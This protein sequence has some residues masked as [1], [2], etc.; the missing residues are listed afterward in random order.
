MDVKACELACGETKTR[1][2]CKGGR[3]AKLSP[4][5]IKT[6]RAPGQNR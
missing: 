2:G 4:K 3:P 5:E 1:G 6:I